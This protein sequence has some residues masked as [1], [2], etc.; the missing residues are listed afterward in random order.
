LGPRA[1]TIVVCLLAACGGRLAA[2]GS[3]AD[4][5][6]FDASVEFDA[7]GSSSDATVPALDASLSTPDDVAVPQEAAADVASS[8]DASSC[9][10][11]SQGELCS[12]GR[13]FFL[14]AGNQLCLGP[15]DACE[16]DCVSVC[17]D[18]EFG[19]ICAV[20]SPPPF[21]NCRLLDASIGGTPYCCPCD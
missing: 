8:D 17:T 15:V 1:F 6:D 19:A 2:P 20:N 7:L 10:I 9:P 18:A 5:G 13:Y 14:C 12:H 4:A 16:G 3:S 11:V 21:A